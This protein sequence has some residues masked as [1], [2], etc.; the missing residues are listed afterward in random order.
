MSFLKVLLTYIT[1]DF[2]VKC[3]DE[4]KVPYINRIGS[5]LIPNEFRMNNFLDKTEA[6]FY[7]FQ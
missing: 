6:D 7:L 1:K 3:F 4:K 5:R 2:F